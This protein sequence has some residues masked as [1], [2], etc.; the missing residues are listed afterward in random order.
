MSYTSSADAR[1]HYEEVMASGDREFT[2]GN[3]IVALDL[4]QKAE[5]D[6]NA[7]YSSASYKN[8]AHEK[9]VEATDK[10]ISEWK[11]QVT[12]LLDKNR[13]A[14]AKT[15]TLALPANLVFSGNT[16]AEFKTLV[17]KIDEDLERRTATI[18][19]EMLADVYAHQGKLSPS[20]KEELAEM[21]KVVPNNY[22]LNFIMDKAK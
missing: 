11:E 22:W 9:A 19:D 5:N 10:I 4:F 7:S 14:R 2:K 18:I 16:E 6:Y 15:L 21:I 20:A 1:A 13:V 3:Y 8:A 12:P 17:S